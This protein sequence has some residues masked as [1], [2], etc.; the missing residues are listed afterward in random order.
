MMN[1]G[2]VERFAE[3]AEGAGA[4]QQQEGIAIIDVD[5]ASPAFG[6]I[7]TD[8]PLPPDLV[9][10]HIFYNKDHQGY[11]GARQVRATCH[12]HEEAALYAG[13]GR[14]PGC[15]VLEGVVFSEDNQAFYVGCMGAERLGRDAVAYKP[16]RTVSLDKPYPHGVVI[17]EDRSIARD[18]TVRATD[19]GDA[20]EAISVVELSAGESRSARS[21]SRTRRRLRAKRR[22]NS[23]C[24][25]RQSTRRLCH[26]HVWRHALI[27]RWDTQKKDFEAAQ[28]FD[29]AS[30]RN[31]V[32]LE[33]YFNGK[34]NRLY[35]TTAKPGELH[36]F[37]V[38]GNVEQP[39][40]IKSIPI[41]EGHHRATPT[42]ITP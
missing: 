13:R 34:G 37:D 18:S 1:W 28:A 26:Q 8:I 27:N 40:L 30:V 4:A 38:S 12:R 23:C 41:A 14:D 19:L 7:V 24:A 10:H 21:R 3:I 31:S 22:S 16:L 33:I 11:R 25:W 35:V 6:K 32:P 9:A 20:G 2:Q 5:P 39:K 36:I 15:S 29:F 17:E 42:S